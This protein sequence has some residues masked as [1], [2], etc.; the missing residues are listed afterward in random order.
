MSSRI[1]DARFPFRDGA[2]PGV[3]GQLIGASISFEHRRCQAN[4]APDYHEFQIVLRWN[5]VIFI[6]LA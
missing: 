4:F 2:L 3:P 1:L 5:C 6:K